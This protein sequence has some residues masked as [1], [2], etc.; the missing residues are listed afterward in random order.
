M[1][2]IGTEPPRKLNFLAT[3]NAEELIRRCWKTALLLPEL[4][5]ALAVHKA[6]RPGRLFDITDYPED[7]RELIAHMLGEGEVAGVAMLENGITAQMQEAVMAGVWR[8]RFT[9]AG[10]RLVGDYIEV[11]SVPAAVRRASSRLPVSIG[12]GAAPAGAM[13]VMPVLTEISDRITHHRDG[14]PAHV[15]NFLLFPMSPEDMAFLQ[16]SLGVGP[17]RLTSRGYG[18]CRIVATGT[19]NVWSLQSYNAMG[20]IILDTLEICDIPS[21]AIAAE[22]DFHD[23]AVRLSEM[24]EVYFK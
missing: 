3:S 20:T 11:G 7:D 24:E 17:V 12:H 10:D 13:N 5:N 22:E 8:I 19:R 6:D 1:T 15:I 16:Y 21:A 14:D 23:S 18:T 4:A 9:A 2:V